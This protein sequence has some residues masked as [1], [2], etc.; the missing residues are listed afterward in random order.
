MYFP[1]MTH[2]LSS[3]I[4][5]Y[6]H[7]R[8]KRGRGKEGRKARHNIP[9]ILHPAPGAPPFPIAQ[10]AVFQPHYIAL[11]ADRNSRSL[12]RCAQGAICNAMQ[13]KKPRLRALAL[14]ARFFAC[15]IARRVWKVISKGKRDMFFFQQKVI[16]SGTYVLCNRVYTRQS[17]IF[18]WEGGEGGETE[19]RADRGPRSLA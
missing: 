8:Q 14:P 12:I 19:M 18:W 15:T 10:P 1:N 13:K 5:R 16:E 4:L 6:L 2:L 11:A 17:V 3:P 9:S 7:A